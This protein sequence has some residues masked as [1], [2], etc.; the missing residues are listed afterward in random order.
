MQS[1]ISNLQSSVMLS[2]GVDLIE[3]ARIEQS[4]ARNGDRFI[5]R[6]YT[7][8]ELD[9]CNGNL[10]RLAARFAIKEAVGK[11]LGTGIGDIRWK[12]VEIVC[13]ERARPFLKLHD[14]AKEL[15]DELGLHHWSISIS[16]TDTHAV[17]FVVAIGNS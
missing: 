17:G 6:I 13:D 2:T 10:A 16:H 4:I 15:A 8:Q 12:D 11:A 3:I 9:Y 1:P 7:E 14:A 5:S